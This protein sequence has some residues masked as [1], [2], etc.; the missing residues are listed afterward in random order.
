[1]AIMVEDVAVVAERLYQPF[2][3]EFKFSGAPSTYHSEDRRSPTRRMFSSTG[4][5]KNTKSR[6]SS[7]KRKIKSNRSSVPTRRKLIGEY[8]DT[9]VQGNQEDLFSSLFFGG[10]EGVN[11]EVAP[12]NERQRVSGGFRRFRESGSGT[13]SGRGRILMKSGPR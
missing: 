8:S 6:G 1:M 7:I 10:G 12:N 11:G 5:P 13:I 3:R 4:Q 2:L 9:V